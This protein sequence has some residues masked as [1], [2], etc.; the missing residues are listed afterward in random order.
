VGFVTDYKFLYD[1]LDK[2]EVVSTMIRTLAYDA[3]GSIL[4]CQFNGGT[5]YAY[6]DVPEQTY[7][8]ILSEDGMIEGSVG[9]AFNRLVKSNEGYVDFLIFDPK[10]DEI[11]SVA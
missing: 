2:V 9:K 4:F 11:W 7:L 10:T 1:Q 5:I 8:S 6:F 3:E